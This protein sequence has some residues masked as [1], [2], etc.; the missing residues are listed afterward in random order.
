[1]IG[2]VTNFSQYFK[3]EVITMLRNLIVNFG[4]K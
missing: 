3:A 2:H 4:S 1:M